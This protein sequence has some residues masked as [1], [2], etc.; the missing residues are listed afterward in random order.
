MTSCERTQSSAYREDFRWRIVWQ[1]EGLKYSN[2]MISANLNIR[3]FL[4]NSKL[5]T[6]TY[7]TAPK[8]VQQ[9]EIPVAMVDALGMPTI[10]F[11]HSAA[12]L[13]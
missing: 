4:I 5:Y 9:Q 11:T 7:A 12:D 13:Q 3:R 6:C 8:S 2:K 10:F 1:K